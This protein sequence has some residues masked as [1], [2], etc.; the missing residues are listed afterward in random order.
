MSRLLPLLKKIGLYS[1]FQ[2]VS[3]LY[4]AI[5]E[6]P[7]S[8]HDPETRRYARMFN[9]LLVM[10][11]PVIF[12]ALGVQVLIEPVRDTATSTTIQAILIGI[13]V[14]IVIYWLPR[15][16][17]IK[18]NLRHISYVAILVGLIIILVVASMSGPPHLELAFLIFLPLVGTML[19]SLW[20]TF[21]LCVVT[22]TC[23]V[24]FGIN[25]TTMPRGFFKDLLVFTALTE[26]FILFVAQQRNR[27]ELD[28]QQFAIEQTRSTILKE[29]LTNLSH[30]FRTP[31]TV[32]N[33]NAQMMAYAIEPDKRQERIVR[34]TDQTMRLNR[35]LD[36]IL[37]ISNLEHEVSE[38]REMLDFHSLLREV[39]AEFGS[40]AKD[41][42]I[43]LTHELSPTA[44]QINARHDHIRRLMV[45]LLENA[46]QYTP[47]GGSI[48]IRTH[49]PT[50]SRIV[51]TEVSDTGIGI[52][53]ED[54]NQVFDPFFRA[55]KARAMDEGG[56][57]LGLS[58]ARRIVELYD[59]DIEA[60][61]QSG[62]GST[63]H[64][65]LPTIN[66]RR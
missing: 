38:K 66:T 9:G 20:E 25:M 47:A 52:I 41:K 8:V 53:E 4:V 58:I 28:R 50:T 32:I 55:D 61:S 43:A 34:I 27:L 62:Q 7:V 42:N 11:I 5:I 14:P 49:V 12:I 63:F 35:I 30:D 60:E 24:V 21:L 57:G 33:T 31:L 1:I 23:L 45:I 18:V 22:F 51:V 15:I 16:A 46:V 56:A 10:I 6:P 59:G 2:S 17:P 19:F 54:L 3:R 37:Y 65:K 36:D 64:F 26:T 40:L 29:M 39:V 44:V 13:T 48:T